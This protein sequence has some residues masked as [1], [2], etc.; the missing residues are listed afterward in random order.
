MPLKWIDPPPS[1]SIIRT[2]SWVEWIEGLNRFPGRWALIAIVDTQGKAGGAALR[3]R[4]GSKDFG[5]MRGDYEAVSRY[6]DGD[7]HVY[8]RYT[9]IK[10]PKD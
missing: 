5:I 9:R 1:S 8:A 6:I 2:P 3:I 7:Y 10:N 4:R